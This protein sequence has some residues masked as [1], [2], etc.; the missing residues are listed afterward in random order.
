MCKLNQNSASEF[1]SK[2]NAISN[3]YREEKRNSRKGKHVDIL[4]CIR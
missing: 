2:T 1:A 3:M 4:F